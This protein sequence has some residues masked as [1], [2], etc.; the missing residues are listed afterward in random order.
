MKNKITWAV[1]AVCGISI[2]VSYHLGEIKK[3]KKANSNLMEIIKTANLDN[4]KLVENIEGLKQADKY[5]KEEKVRQDSDALTKTLQSEAA[6]Y[7]L[8]HPSALDK[9]KL[10]LE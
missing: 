6:E 2:M 5:R 1:V 10:E 8:K 7:N 4:F 9:A 3:L